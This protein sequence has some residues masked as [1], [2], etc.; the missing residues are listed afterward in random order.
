MVAESETDREDLDNSSIE[1]KGNFHRMIRR[2]A[3]VKPA[4]AVT[5]VSR[6]QRPYVPLR[7]K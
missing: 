3:G 5:C 4:A 6:A 2:A 1:V 7:E